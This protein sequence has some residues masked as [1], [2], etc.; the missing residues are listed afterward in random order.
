MRC[1][2]PDEGRI[3]ERLWQNG[4]KVGNSSVMEAAARRLFIF[5]IGYAGREIAR[6]AMAAGW[7]VAGTVTN[8]AKVSELA[9]S[10]I[11]AGLF[12]AGNFQAGS[13]LRSASHVVC[14]IPPEAAGDPAL[15]QCIEC[16]R[17]QPERPA[18]L[19]YLSTT[20]VYG[21][22]DGS[23]VDETAAPNPGPP[24]SRH[25]LLA[26]QG[27]RA[28]GMAEGI[29]VDIFRLP[30]IYGPGRSVLD[31]LRAGTARAID[32]PGQ[33]FGRIHVVDLARVVLAAMQRSSPLPGA[34][35]NVVDDEPAAQPEVVAYAARLLGLSPPP[36]VPW[37]DAAP[38]M[39]EIARSFYAENRRVRN[40]RIKRDLAIKLAYPT[41]REG[42]RAIAAV[43]GGAKC[44]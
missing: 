15:P 12:I 29:V 38:G 17:R 28:L 31:Q 44:A 20:G 39:S 3:I 30:A 33:V 35:Y 27:W 6:Q 22:T 41:Y 26:E 11:E 25:R 43:A 34:F 32:K 8:E 2:P 5:G 36:I 1:F 40:E 37:E 42:L 24:R 10:G 13:A 9:R 7:R 21:N 4:R 19:G 23:W 18:W 16:L 14:S